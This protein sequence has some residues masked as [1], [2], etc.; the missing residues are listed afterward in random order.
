LEKRFVFTAKSARTVKFDANR[1]FH[2]AYNVHV[3]SLSWDQIDCS[4]RLRVWRHLRS[5]DGSV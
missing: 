2:V 3:V 1:L 4:D 5:N